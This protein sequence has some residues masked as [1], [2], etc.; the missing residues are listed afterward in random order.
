MSVATANVYLLR[1]QTIGHANG[2]AT[3]APSF[4]ERAKKAILAVAEAGALTTRG[5]S[6]R[7]AFRMW[8]I[9]GVA[10][11]CNTSS[12]D[13][14]YCSTLAVSVGT[15]RSLASRLPSLM[16]VVQTWPNRITVIYQ[17]LEIQYCPRVP[18]NPL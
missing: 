6:T 3:S 14:S 5:E 4:T 11:P 1:I 16:L 8:A 12:T 18:V 15:N 9:S 17:S 7:S 2:L 13:G 10:L